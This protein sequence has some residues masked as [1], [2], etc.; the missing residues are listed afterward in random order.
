MTVYNPHHEM[1]CLLSWDAHT[2]F[3]AA[4]LSC[5]LSVGLSAVSFVFQ[6]KSLDL[7]NNWK[8]CFMLFGWDCLISFVACTKSSALDL[9]SLFVFFLNHGNNSVITHFNCLL[10]SSRPFLVFL[11]WPVHSFYVRMND[12]ADMVTPK[13]FA[14][15]DWFILFL[16][17]NDGFPYLQIHL[18]GPHSEISNELVS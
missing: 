12:T 2:A 15:S 4:T 16:Q 3:I 1:L 8:A 6:I 5:C 13:V 9:V 14:V 7:I 10:W 18:S 17:S 11:S